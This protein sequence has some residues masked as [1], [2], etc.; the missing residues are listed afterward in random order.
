MG[1]REERVTSEENS[2]RQAG[3]SEVSLHVL[4]SHMTSLIPIRN[5]IGSYFVT[6]IEEIVK[7]YSILQNSQ[8]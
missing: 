8:R 4:I 1:G 3:I 7:M 5:W 6:L 2:R